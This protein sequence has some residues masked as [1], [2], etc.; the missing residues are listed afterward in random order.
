MNRSLLRIP[1]MLLTAVLLFLAWPVGAFSEAPAAAQAEEDKAWCAAWCLNRMD[2]I[3]GVSQDEH[4]PPDFALGRELTR[5][6]ALAIV[7]RLTGAEEEAYQGNWATPFTDVSSWARPYVGYAY[8]HGMTKGT[9][10]TA[11]SGT[12]TV[13]SEQYLTFLLRA[14][15]YSDES[16]FKW[17]APFA[18][19][20]SLGLTA[21]EYSR[22]CSFLRGDVMY[23]TWNALTVRF[24]DS[25]RCFA[26]DLSSLPSNAERVFTYNPCFLFRCGGEGKNSPEQ[27]ICLGTDCREIARFTSETAGSLVTLRPYGTTRNY[28]DDRYYYGLCGL[29]HYKDGTFTQVTPLPV[30]DLVFYRQGAGSSGPV[31]LTTDGPFIQTAFGTCSGDTIIEFPGEMIREKIVWLSP[32]DGFGKPVD[33]IYALDGSLAFRRAEKTEDGL[34]RI[35]YYAF[36]ASGIECFSCTLVEELWQSGDFQYDHWKQEKDRLAAAGPER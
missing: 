16:D 3:R 11:F 36:V 19:A 30:C 23:I 26:G 17:D 27:L 10:T 22:G 29:Y 24:K 8:E 31:I 15:G 13:T 35:Y 34:Y 9:S 1:I 20:D 12:K 25:T 4:Q 28:I 18:L 5:E 14:L 6:E 7:I 33:M 21:G 32:E 2:L